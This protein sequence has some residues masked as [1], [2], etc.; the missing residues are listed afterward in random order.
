M[1]KAYEISPGIWWVGAIEW[2]LRYIHGFSIP[3]G[4]TNNAYI[5]MDEHITLID[6]CTEEYWPQLMERISDVVDPERISYIISN[7]SEKDHAGSLREVLARAPHAKVVTSQKGKAILETYIGTERELIPVK[8]GDT[9]Q[10]GKRTLTFTLTPMVH[11]PDNMVT[12]SE[13]DKILFSNDAFGQFL[14][15]SECFDD[16]ADKCLIFHEAKKYFANIILPFKKQ[17]AKAVAAVRGLELDLIAPSHGVIWRSYISE[18][19][20]TYDA[21]CTAEPEDSAVVVYASMYGST[22]RMAWAAAEAFMAKGVSVRMYDLHVSDI[23]DI[24]TEVMSAKYLLVGSACHNMTVLPEA[25]A[26]LTYLKGLAQKLGSGRKAM[27]F[28]SYGWADVA[29]VEIANVLQ[30]CGYDVADAPQTCE[31][32]DTPADTQAM[33]QSVSDLIS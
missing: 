30:A 27:A 6:T 20:D 15:T 33:F 29:Q 17:T 10:I 18:I 24:M 3:N 4:S 21:W 25:G 31:W 2:N 19:L 13:A 1:F 12:Y 5:I 7:H 9:L 8:T 23:S 22:E 11:W 16:Q 28:G 14:A 26:F 32:N